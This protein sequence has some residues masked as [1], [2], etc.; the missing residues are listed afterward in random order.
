ML[1]EYPGDY[2]LEGADMSGTDLS[3]AKLYGAKLSEILKLENAK[4]LK[5]TNLRRVVKG[6][7]KEQLAIC[8]AKG[9]I[10]DEEAATSSSQSPVSP[11]IPSQSNDTQTSSAPPTQGSI[12]P[13]DT[14]ES[15]ATSSQPSPRA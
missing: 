4:S 15:C 8:K 13:S 10:I 1:L 6:L 3:E 9:A 12:P 7:T 11:P 2:Y 5:G 14:D